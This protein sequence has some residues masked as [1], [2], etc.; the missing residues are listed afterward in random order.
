VWF[1][2]FD[3]VLKLCD[4]SNVKRCY[5]SLSFLI[6]IS[7]QGKSAFSTQISANLKSNN[8]VNHQRQHKNMTYLTVN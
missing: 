3:A 7:F 1:H 8:V 2:L 5:S 6:M 4:S